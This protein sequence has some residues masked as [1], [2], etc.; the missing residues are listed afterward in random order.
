MDSERAAT[1][2]HKSSYDQK[3]SQPTDSILASLYTEHLSEGPYRR[4]SM[5]KYLSYD[6]E[7]IDT[8]DF[9]STDAFSFD[10]MHSVHLQRSISTIK[11][12]EEYLL[13]NVYGSEPLQDQIQKFCHEFTD[14]FSTKLKVDTATLPPF[15]VDCDVSKWES[16]T[17]NKLPPRMQSAKKQAETIRSC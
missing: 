10:D 4:E 2:S 3:V 6:G 11:Q 12:D 14:I 8:D 13:V 17:S 5:Q 7:D 1:H 16:L 9:R 15:K